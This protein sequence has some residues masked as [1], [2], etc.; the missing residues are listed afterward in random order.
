MFEKILFDLD[1]TL[2]DPKTGITKCVQYALNHF[3][4][5]EEADNL[6]KFIGPPLI[7]SFM[8]FYGFS[9][10]KAREATD[11]YRERF[12][13]IGKFENEVYAGIPEMLK[14]LKE[15]GAILAVAS[16][17]PEPFVNDILEYFDLSGY[18]DVVVGSLLNET[19]T[20]KEEV[21]EEALKRLDIAYD[22]SL[23]SENGIT[24]KA[25]KESV[26]MVGD[27]KFDVASARD[28]GITAVGVAYGYA[29]KG[30]LEAENP[31]FIAKTVAELK[32]YLLN[33]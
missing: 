30:E 25:P 11:K 24:I 10:D 19:R 29:E 20:K 22:G 6:T 26:A 17:K 27:R 12:A 9:L 8:E 15:K 23:G 21:I 14:S 32:E 3:G 18:F 28:M 4:I 13:P 16:S 33:S 5:E 1:G 7:D 31:D 2:T